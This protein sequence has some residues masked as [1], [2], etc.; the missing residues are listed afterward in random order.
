M[1]GPRKPQALSVEVDPKAMARSQ[2]PGCSF[3]FIDN[4]LPWLQRF[5]ITFS[6]KSHRTNRRNLLKPARGLKEG[7]S[8][9]RVLDEAQLHYCI[10]PE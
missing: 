8:T 10:T 9:R 2:A 4:G 7:R 3:R 1:T 5:S 6:I